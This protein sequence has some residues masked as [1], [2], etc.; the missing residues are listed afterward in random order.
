MA[1]GF[2]GLDWIPEGVTMLYPMFAMVVLTLG[3]GI[4]TIFT[5]FKSV[6]NK[7]ISPRYYQTMTTQ[8]GEVV[9]DFVHRTTRALNNQFELPVLF[10]V[11]GTLAIVMQMES[12]V[13]IA[14]AWF[15]VASRVLHAIIYLTYNNLTHRLLIFWVGIIAVVELWILLLAA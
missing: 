10:Y 1:A 8:K 3:I 15:F 5:R 4:I 11:A 2:T 9:P 12:T 13:A 6:K 14:T 7:D